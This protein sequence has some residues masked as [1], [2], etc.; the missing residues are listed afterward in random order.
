MA[1]N[2]Y[3]LPLHD[4]TKELNHHYLSTDVFVKN[5]KTGNYH[6][7]EGCG[8]K[9]IITASNANGYKILSDHKLS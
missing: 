5:K 2:G 6:Q 1:Y 7:K 8:R 3:G 4:I 9:Q